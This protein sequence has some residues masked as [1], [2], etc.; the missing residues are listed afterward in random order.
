[1]GKTLTL[2]AVTAAVLLLG[3]VRP[4]RAMEASCNTDLLRCYEAA[5]RIDNFWYRWAAGLDCEFAYVE[6]ARKTILGG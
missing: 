2:L 5:A 6:C 4:A 3:D 1:M